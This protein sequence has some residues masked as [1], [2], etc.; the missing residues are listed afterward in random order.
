MSRRVKNDSYSFYIDNKIWPP[1]TYIDRQKKNEIKFNFHMI[2]KNLWINSWWPTPR[3]A[4]SLSY[5]IC[6][7][8]TIR[9]SFKSLTKPRSRALKMSRG[10]SITQTSS[11]TR[12][13]LVYLYV[14]IQYECN[15]TLLYWKSHIF[16]FP[17]PGDWHPKRGQINLIGS[18]YHLA[19]DWTDWLVVS[20]EG[21]ITRKE[22]KKR[23]DTHTRTP[24]ANKCINHFLLHILLGL[25][26]NY[27]QLTAHEDSLP[28]SE[29]R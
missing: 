13:L 28:R 9:Q 4:Q 10:S 12:K 3:I 1:I 11:S 22:R 29:R 24:S 20:S 17:L 16:T 14:Y 8:E 21:V 5:T 15:N 7:Y 19:L 23:I 25:S 27:C 6:L 2:K 18:K 26:I